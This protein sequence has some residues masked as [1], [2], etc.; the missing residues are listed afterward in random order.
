MLLLLLLVVVVVLII[1]LIDNVIGVNYDH[2]LV[3]FTIVLNNCMY[4]APSNFNL[5]NVGLH[6]H[7]STENY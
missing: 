7:L 6:F 3:N 4:V 1:V 5:Y 2:I